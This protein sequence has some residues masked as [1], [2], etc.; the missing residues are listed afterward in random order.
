MNFKYYFVQSYYITVCFLEALQALSVNEHTQSRAKREAFSN[1][2]K[3][4]A[5]VSIFLFHKESR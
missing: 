3:R 4:I 2:E 5:G 1:D